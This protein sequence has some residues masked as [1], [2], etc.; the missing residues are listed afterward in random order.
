MTSSNPRR[1]NG[2]RRN[3]VRAQVLREEDIC[4]LCG[5]PVDKTLPPHQ[6]GSPEIDEVVPIALG[7]SPIDRANCRLSHRLCNVRRGQ[8]TKRQ[9]RARAKLEPFTTSR[10]W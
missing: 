5:E 4:W 3:Q 6:D 10:S 1:A 2:H 8:E 9:V 7:G